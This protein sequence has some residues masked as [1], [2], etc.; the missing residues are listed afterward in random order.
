[1]ISGVAFLN[2]I[3]P[4]SHAIPGPAGRYDAQAKRLVPAQSS[5]VH[6]H[7]DLTVG[8]Q[9]LY[10]VPADAATIYDT[11]NSYN[12]DFSS[13]TSYTGSGVTIGI[14]GD[15]PSRPAPSRIS[16]PAS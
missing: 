8:G 10:M 16:A 2:T 9:Y 5:A 4:L 6:A 12:G 11:P 1:M 15:A 13:A 3:Q 14:G 7:P